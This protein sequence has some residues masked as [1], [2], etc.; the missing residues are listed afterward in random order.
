MKNKDFGKVIPLAVSQKEIWL[1]Y[2]AWP[3]SAHLNL[4][5]VLEFSG[6]LSESLIKQSLNQMVSDNEALRLIPQNDG[7]QYLL[8]KFTPELE[9]KDFTD[10][11]NPYDACMDWQKIWMKQPF[12]IGDNPPWRFAWLKASEESYFIAIQFHHTIMDGWG[13]SVILLKWAEYY[14]ELSNGQTRSKRNEVGYLNF[15]DESNAFLTSASF[16]KSAKFWKTNLES[17]PE[18]LLDKKFTKASSDTMP[19]AYVVEHNVKRDSY[20]KVEQFSESLGVT[21]YHILLASIAIYFSKAYG[22][23]TIVLGAPSLNRS[24][25]KYKSTIGMFIS[26]M[27]LLI[28][29]ND[30]DTALE[31]AQRIAKL[32]RNVYRYSKFPLSEVMK[33]VRA[34]QNGKDRIFD[35]IVSYEK[36]EYEC[37]FGEAEC[38]DSQQT[39]SGKARFPLGITLCEFHDQNDVKLVLEA[40]EEYFS[41]A[42]TQLL[43]RRIEFTLLQIANTPECL[44]KDILL[45]DES[46]RR[47]LL[48]ALPTNV[49]K[50]TEIEP[51]ISQFLRKA[52]L[53]P[54][55]IALKT[56][57]DALTYAQVTNRAKSLAI[58]MLNSGF[59]PGDIAA[60]FIERGPTSIIALLAT[61]IAGGAFLTLDPDA[62][63]ERV[64][65]ILDDSKATALLTTQSLSP[66]V[67]EINTSATRIDIESIKALAN[68]ELEIDFHKISGSDLAYVIYTS[69]TTGKPKGVKIQH[70]ALARRIAW[71]S[72]SWQINELDVI[73]QTIQLTFDPAILEIFV[74]LTNGASIA[75]PPPGRILPESLASFCIR[76]EVTFI[77][78]VPS[79]LQRFLDG[80]EDFSKFKLRIVI[81][82]GEVLPAHLA[83][84]LESKTGAT[85]FNVYGPTEAT[86]LATEWLF[87]DSENTYLKLPIGRPI[88]DTSIYILDEALSPVPFGVSGDIYIGGQCLAEGYLGNQELTD[89]VFLNSPHIEGERLYKTG[90]AGWLSLDGQLHFIGRVD[91]QVKYKGYRV[92]L[93]EIEQALSAIDGVSQAAV[94]II[95]SD[96]GQEL[97]A[98]ISGG[99]LE[100]AHY[101]RQ[102]LARKLP[103]YMVPTKICFLAEL[104]LSNTGKVNYNNLPLQF[105]V[106]T[107][108]EQREPRGKIEQSLVK[109]WQKVLNREDIK[110]HDNF[111]LLG[112]DSLAAVIV[113]TNIHEQLGV[114]LPLYKLVEYPSIA[115][116]API[117]N[118]DLGSP[119]LLVSFGNTT[120]NNALYIAASGHGDLLRFKALAKN[121]KGACDVHM[122]QPPTQDKNLTFDELGKLYA[123]QILNNQSKTIYLAGFSI[124]GIA[125]LETAR[126]LQKQHVD[127]ELLIL[128]DTV[129]VKLPKV[130]YKIWRWLSWLTSKLKFVNPLI[131][132][133]KLSAIL[134]DTGLY[135]QAEA[136]YEYQPEPYKNPTLL[137]KTVANSWLKGFLFGQW[138]RTMN[139][140][141]REDE[142]EGGHSSIFKIGKIEKLAETIMKYLK[143]NKK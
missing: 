115:E 79:V 66:R 46:E 138:R 22:R 35:I 64:T 26:V 67:E 33:E 113:L 59:A 56:D 121:L 5:G 68:E 29:V 16:E 98:W 127:V 11:E 141:L 57:D 41:D 83:Q 94:K 19:N 37:Y 47:Q 89:R 9:I 133:R 102:A 36:Q 80:V 28:E 134:N 132:D 78:F 58:T 42:E 117:I 18:P 44:V 104:P 76:H 38:I 3:D 82:G 48:E 43:G 107:S 86:I 53:V 110:I 118:K 139:G 17:L 96:S 40:N 7:S 6:P 39:F 50:L 14:S 45:I 25:K 49:P 128:I 135:S 2:L 99:K 8:E 70:D 97:A 105:S 112:G 114:K 32:L 73:A 27:P 31:L 122:L 52:E 123:E 103:D 62:P 69:G 60:V 131:N 51:V 125:A 55:S 65:E 90:D 20:H 81:C 15:I 71:G 63:I 95:D 12:V 30:E 4:G 54:D 124:G 108:E 92:E 34:I 126:E 119:Q 142:V 129:F 77:I 116:L 101:I 120:R 88:A 10:A 75:F 87:N 93:Q 23:K 136:L 143:E 106:V 72:S 74:A 21:N 24:G 111:F 85:V 13:T 100:S 1:D 84:R 91:S 61:N 130:G 140:N 137:I 109:I